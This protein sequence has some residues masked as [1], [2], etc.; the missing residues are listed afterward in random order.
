MNNILL[1]IIKTKNVM[2]VQ[3]LWVLA[4]SERYNEMVTGSIEELEWN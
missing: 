3:Y 4:I 2:K 1:Y